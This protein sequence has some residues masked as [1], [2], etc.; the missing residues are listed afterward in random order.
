MAFTAPMR[1]CASGTGR[2]ERSNKQQRG[3]GFGDLG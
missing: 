3:Q 1:S 2:E